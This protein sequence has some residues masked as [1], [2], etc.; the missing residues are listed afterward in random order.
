MVDVDWLFKMLT[1]T[2]ASVLICMVLD[3]IFKGK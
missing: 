2:L 1:F 3:S